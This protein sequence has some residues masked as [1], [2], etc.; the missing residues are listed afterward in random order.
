MGSRVWSLGFRDSGFGFG[1]RVKGFGI[2]VSGFGL[3][4]RVQGLGLRGY[5]ASWCTLQPGLAKKL[6]EG[7]G[8]FRIMGRWE[9]A[10]AGNGESHPQSGNESY[11]SGP[12][13]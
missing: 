1:L 10:S 13:E 12:E 7:N 9:V 6:I 8:G 11:C 3:G 5:A 2:R 4:L